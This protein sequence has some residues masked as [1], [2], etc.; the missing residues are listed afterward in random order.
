MPRISPHA[1]VAETAVLAGDVRVGAFCHIGPEVELGPGCEIGSN[2]TIVGRTTLGART[3]VYPMAVIGESPPGGAGTG[4]C[5]LGE[6]NAI[7][8]HV[9]IFAGTDAPTRIGNHN[10]IMIASQVGAG[11]VVGDH[12]I[13][14]NCSRIGAG[15][16]VEDYVRMS[17]FASVADGARVGA[18]SF[19]AGYACVRRDAPP[20]V[21][22][23]GSPVRARGINTRNLKACG[24]DEKDI[25]EL[26]GAFRELFSGRDGKVS[27]KALRK[28]EAAGKGSAH[29]RKLLAAVGAG[30]GAGDADG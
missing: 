5:V 12:G 7:R 2:V 13:F 9:T 10:L 25:R 3:R 29:V 26:K 20:Y 22:L 11:A 4:A 19:V 16:A 30:A 14:D 23:Q 21:M 24:F 17:G 15:A 8:E 6:A 27:R 1:T 18:Y 28:L